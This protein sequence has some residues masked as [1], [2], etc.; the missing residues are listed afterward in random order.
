MIVA[1]FVEP[2]VTLE[3]TVAPELTEALQVFLRSRLRDLAAELS[4]AHARENGDG[5][6]AL[7][8]RAHQER[9]ARSHAS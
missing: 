3:V 7:E 8:T 6:K 9:E 4:A 2:L 1:N 5:P